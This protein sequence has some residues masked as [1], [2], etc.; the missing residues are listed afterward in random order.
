MIEQ[1]RLNQ[2]LQNALPEVVEAFKKEL[3]S[4]VVWKARDEAAKIVS[5]E[6]TAWVKENV[7][8]ELKRSLDES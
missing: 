5:D 1:E 6:V 8:P 2:M 4:Q 3:T 7:L